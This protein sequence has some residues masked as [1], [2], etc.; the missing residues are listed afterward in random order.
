MAHEVTL[1]SLQESEREVILQV[2]YRDRVVQ[3]IEEERIRRTLLFNFRGHRKLKT[4][5]Q[6]LR[7]KGSK[8][9]SQE[10]KEES[11]ARCQ[12]GLG[13]LLN[14]GAVCQGCSHRVCSECRVFLRR[15]RAWKCTVCFEDSPLQGFM[16]LNQSLIQ[17]N[18]KIKT[19]EWF[20]EERAKKF[21]T[22]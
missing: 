14:R 10:Y 21:P 8:G 7:W 17:R 9:A 18:V 13:L 15:T 6:H 3:N 22:E 1:N 4:H 12:R 16:D 20:F 2:L 19:G 11:C 5:L